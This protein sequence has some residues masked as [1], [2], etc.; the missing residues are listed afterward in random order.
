MRKQQSAP[1]LKLSNSAGDLDLVGAKE[2]KRA[3][4][5]AANETGK[6]VT[7]SNPTTG[8]VVATEQPDDLS[9]PPALDRIKGRTKEQVDA[10]R[11]ELIE[12]DK[13]RDQAQRRLLSKTQTKQETKMQTQVQT[14]KTSRKQPVAK[15]KAVKKT[16]AKAKSNG[17]GKKANGNGKAAH[18]VV[19]RDGGPEKGSLIEKILKLCERAQGATRKELFDLTDWT[20]NYAWKWGLSNK[21]GT[22]FADR[23]G[24][25]LTVI[26]RK[27]GSSAYKVAKK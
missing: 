21:H 9:I 15:A 18:K 4:K 19:H 23:H 6:P 3:A 7:V 8:K 1:V 20:R 13:R 5:L 12:R 11:I 14:E 27:D 2:A 25:K 16:A 26:E 24:Y 17:N 22:G 10:E